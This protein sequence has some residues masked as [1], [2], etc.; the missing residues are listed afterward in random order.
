MGPDQD[1]DALKAYQLALAIDDAR[2]AWWFQLGLLHKWRGRF[3][4]GAR[5]QPQGDR[6]GGGRAAA[7]SGTW[8]DLRHGPGRWRRLALEV[9]QKLRH[10][11]ASSPRAACPSCP[12]CR[13]M[14]VRVATLGEDTGAGRPAAAPRRLPSRWCWVR[15]ALPCHGVVQSPTA[16]RA[17]VDYGDVV[18]WDGAPV[19]VNTIDERPGAGFS[20][21]LG[22]APRRRATP[23][24]R[25]HA[26]SV[27]PGRGPR[28]S[29]GRGRD[30][31][32]IRSSAAVTSGGL[33][34]GKLIV[35]GG[36]RARSRCAASSRRPCARDRDS[37]WPCPSCTS[38]SAIRPPAG[39]AHQA[40]GGIERN[41]RKLGPFATALTIVRP[42]RAQSVSIVRGPDCFASQ[43]GQSWS[44]VGS[45]TG[46]DRLPTK[47]KAR[48]PPL[49]TR[50][51]R[52]GGQ[53]CA[54]PSGHQR[55]RKGHPVDAQGGRRC[56]QLGQ[57]SSVSKWRPSR[58]WAFALS[59]MVARTLSRTF[60]FNVGPRYRVSSCASELL[61]QAA[62]AGRLVACAHEH[63]RHHE[64]RHQRPHA[65][66]ACCWGSARSTCST[67]WW[68]T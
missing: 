54:L 65:G 15:A 13:A 56:V 37:R 61:G 32:G 38:C 41:A 21:A 29:A 46:P 24:L 25:G 66:C 28:P 40:W 68:P 30:A 50:P 44:K 33:F 4:E 7:C 19:R 64:S 67:P 5:G 42:A 48:P 18:L 14:Q 51:P 52:A 9:W 49:L 1:E 47:A 26:K 62:P 57:T 31:G 3:R 12:A 34:Y 53:G 23:A 17:S 59:M 43:P 60:T 27:G 58:S 45:C 2:G 16:R 8:R 10:A 55:P 11:P 39:K 22:A 63:R 20:V 6:A 35:P 36:G